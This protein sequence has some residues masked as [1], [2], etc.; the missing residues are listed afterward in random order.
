MTR[1]ATKGF[2]S[3]TVTTTEERFPSHEGIAIPVMM[4]LPDNTRK[5]MAV[6]VKKIIRDLP[7]HIHCTRGENSYAHQRTKMGDVFVRP[8]TSSFFTIFKQKISSFFPSYHTALG[9]TNSHC[10]SSRRP[11]PAHT[12]GHITIH[13]VPITVLP[14]GEIAH[15]DPPRQ[16]KA[17]QRQASP[18][19]TMNKKNPPSSM[20]LLSSHQNTIV[21]L[22]WVR[23]R[24]NT[25]NTP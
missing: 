16:S 22:C 7:C 13:E 24:R 19:I 3:T 15:V 12:S 8:K 14:D 1:I 18:S 11:P 17:S 25:P 5:R 20:A 23:T 4:L 9:E 21:L 2:F 6:V 10:Q